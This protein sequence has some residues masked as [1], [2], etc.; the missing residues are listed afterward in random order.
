[1]PDQPPDATAATPSFNDVAATSPSN[2]WI[3]GTTQL[4]LHPWHTLVV[5][6]NGRTWRRV[7]SPDEPGRR[8]SSGLTAVAATSLRNAWAVGF[9]N[10]L[11]H[12]TIIEHWNGVAWK[13]V[14][15]P[16]PPKG[17]F[18]T[19]DDVAATS[20]N[21][22]WAV[23]YETIGPGSNS[24]SL[25]E[26]WNGTNWKQ[27]P[28][29]SI[30]TPGGE[31]IQ[32][33]LSGVTAI[34][35]NNVWAVG[36][37]IVG[38]GSAQTL[39]EHWSGTKWAIVPSPDPQGQFSPTFL[40]GV[41]AISPT[42]I[43][44][45]GSA[46][47]VFAPTATM[48]LRWLGATWQPVKSP[49]NDETVESLSDVSAVSASDAWAVGSYENQISHTNNLTLILRWNG[50]RWLAVRAPF[51]RGAVVDSLGSVAAVSAKQAWAVGSI[52]GGPHDGAA[53]LLRWNGARWAIA[54]LPRLL[55]RHG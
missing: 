47:D 22:A 52:G 49:S 28:S 2:A 25:I 54:A 36:D 6:W 19:L 32:N 21:D 1:V 20:R 41:A 53:L 18:S 35:V 50:R 46:G 3:V 51:P 7:P 26:H 12:S 33:G 40:G 42:D 37:Y 11:N 8:T 4:P 5:H 23:G 43:F 15:S 29:P 14:P 31:Q 10:L 55:G 24:R 30:T 17:K 27:V 9:T 48:I 39:I 13:L 45:V 38:S 34:S 44:A 16:Q